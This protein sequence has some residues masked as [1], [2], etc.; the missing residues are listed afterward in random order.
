LKT[1]KP[2]SKGKPTNRTGNES[3][4][5]VTPRSNESRDRLVTMK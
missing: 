5:I 4:E 2:D 3:H 1:I